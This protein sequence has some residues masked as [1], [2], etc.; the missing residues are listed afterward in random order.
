M[1]GFGP[2]PACRT[3][4]PV[5][6]ILTSHSRLS[7]VWQAT[8]L[9]IAYPNYAYADPETSIVNIFAR[10]VIAAIAA[11]APWLRLRIAP[12]ALNATMR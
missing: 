6:L 10:A 2:D 7:A 3:E 12:L 4:P 9:D 5:L 1:T 8:V 11:I